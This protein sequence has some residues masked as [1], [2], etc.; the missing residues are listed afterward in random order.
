MGYVNIISSQTPKGD[1]GSAFPQLH[2]SLDGGPLYLAHI[3]DIG[4]PSYVGPSWQPPSILPYSVNKLF[5]LNHFVEFHIFHRFDRS[6]FRVVQKCPLYKK[7]WLSWQPKVSNL[8][9]YQKHL[10]R[11]QNN[12]FQMV[13]GKPSTK[14][15][16]T[17]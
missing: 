5:L 10:V 7:I 13:F 4:C 8:K 6:L 15:V 12:L 11:F 16:Q 3:V 17:I 9:S 14:I 2:T 1:L